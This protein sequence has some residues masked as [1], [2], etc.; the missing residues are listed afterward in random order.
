MAVWSRPRFDMSKTKQVYRNGESQI[1]IQDLI[2]SDSGK[3]TCTADNQVAQ[4]QTK[5]ANLVVKYF[6]GIDKSRQYAKAGGKHGDTVTLICKAEGTPEMQFTWLKEDTEL[7]S[8]S[9]YAISSTSAADIFDTKFKSELTV[10]SIAK[11]DYGTY[12]CKARNDRGED[13]F[14][15]RLNGTIRC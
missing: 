15:I 4:P 8:N 7:Q 11:A 6:A 2:R 9:K 10:R 13:Q 14:N 3:F 1:V 12:T 5:K